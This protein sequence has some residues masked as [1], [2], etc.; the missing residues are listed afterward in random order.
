MT[1][2]HRRQGQRHPLTL[3]QRRRGSAGVDAGREASEHHRRAAGCEPVVAVR[4][5][6]DLGDG[7]GAGRDQGGPRVECIECIQ[8][9]QGGRRVLGRQ[10]HP[11][12]GGPTHATGVSGQAACE[13]VQQR[14]LAGSVAPHQ[15]D[16]LTGGQGQPDLAQGHRVAPQH[17]EAVGRHDRA[18]DLARAAAPGPARAAAPGVDGRR[19]GPGR[20][21][22]ALAQ[23]V[24]GPAG[25]AH[26]Q[27]QRVPA[28]DPPEV[29]QRWVDRGSGHGLGRAEQRTDDTVADEQDG[30]GVV[31]DALEAVLGDQHG[32]ADVVDQSVQRGEHLLGSD[33][34][35][36]RRRLVQDQDARAGHEGSGDGHPLLLAAGQVAQRSVAQGAQTEQVQGLLDAA[37]TRVPVARLRADA[38]GDLVVH[39]LGG[40]PGRRVLGHPADQG[41]ERRL[42]GGA[43]V[44]PVDRDTP[45]GHGRAG[46]PGVREGTQ[47]GGLAR[48]RRPHHEHQ[49]TLGHAH[50]DVPQGRLRAIRQA[51]TLEDDHSARPLH[52]CPGVS[53]P[54]GGSRRGRPLGCRP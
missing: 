5:G 30:V 39:G 10:G 15:G 8:C 37:Q 24:R 44:G 16:H 4:G 21:V 31:D 11:H 9:I 25:V 18:P 49:L 6:Q 53:K 14:R 50:G 41:R 29:D 13:G 35:E 40:E 26:R 34:V 28:Q 48:P 7:P 32:H 33:R 38:A 22:E 12:V 54:A 52:R 2:Q 20:G 47:Q 43:R 36:C 42:V 1:G 45:R 51:H 3:R 19:R 17:A 27:R 23:P 46:V